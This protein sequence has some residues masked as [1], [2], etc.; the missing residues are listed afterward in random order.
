MNEKLKQFYNQQ[1]RG[2]NNTLSDTAK[3]KVKDQIFAK[4]NAP[5]VDIQLATDEK[6]WFTLQNL[7]NL[8]T[9]PYVI[10]PLV[11]MLFLSGTTI[12]SASA[13]PGDK[14]YGVKRQVENF[15]LLVAP[16]K[17]MKTKLQVN[18]A[19]RRLNEARIMEEKRLQQFAPQNQDSPAREIDLEKVL[20]EPE[21]LSEDFAKIK[22][23]KAE[24][25]KTKAREDAKQAIESLNKIR[26]SYLEKGQA[27][28][29]KQVDERLKRLLKQKGR[30]SNS[31]SGSVRG[32]NIESSKQE[33]REDRRIEERENRPTDEREDRT[34]LE[35]SRSSDPE[36][37]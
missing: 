14:L 29:A 15:Q 6:R 18:F 1:A 24:K 11:V 35:S 22:D 9:T 27:E 10:A 8:L 13:Q 31:D 4:L 2:I 30:E 3:H 20:N 12:A 36:I 33:N 34:E 16:S 5:N 25:A 37:D 28:K 32:L 17:E 23:E 19:E 7:R 21:E 26:A